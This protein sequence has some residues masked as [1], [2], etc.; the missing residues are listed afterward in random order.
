MG[1]VEY[2]IQLF[3]EQVVVGGVGDYFMQIDQV[4]QVEIQGDIVQYV[5]CV[6]CQWQ[7]EVMLY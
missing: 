3:V 1:E 2:Q 6:Y 5:N 7:I 4:V